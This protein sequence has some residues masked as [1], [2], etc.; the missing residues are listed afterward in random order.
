MAHT[1]P[2][3]NGITGIPAYGI[4]LFGFVND[5]AH[6]HRPVAIAASRMVVVEGTLLEK[7]DR[8]CAKGGGEEGE[9]EKEE[10]GEGRDREWDGGR[11]RGGVLRRRPLRNTQD[12]SCMPPW[13]VSSRTTWACADVLVRR[14]WSPSL[15]CLSTGCMEKGGSRVTMRS[16]AAQNP[17]CG[18]WCFQDGAGG[19]R[20]A[21][22]GRR[23]RR[24]GGGR[25]GWVAIG[26]WI[27]W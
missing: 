2:R 7:N 8:W 26:E 27:E 14:C 20:A 21:G 19:E 11:E 25:E 18:V 13:R 17:I 15:A 9:E 10:E 12:K 4:V 24:G 5:H 22:G 3:R 6:T 1:V 16:M 23:G